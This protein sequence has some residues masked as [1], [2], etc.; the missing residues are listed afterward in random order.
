[1]ARDKMAG[2]F[3]VNRS[4]TSLASASRPLRLPTVHPFPK[5]NQR[6]SR[7]AMICP[8]AGVLPEMTTDVIDV[9][10]GYAVQNVKRDR[11]EPRSTTRLSLSH[12]VNRVLGYSHRAAR[13]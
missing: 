3:N 2:L 10:A 12:L 9:A 5:L 7:P 6:I 1:M 8:P 13:P 4:I 11:I